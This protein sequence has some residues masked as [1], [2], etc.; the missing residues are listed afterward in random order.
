MLCDG[1]WRGRGHD[2]RV[3][4]KRRRWPRRARHC[5]AAL[6]VS[7]HGARLEANRPS[8]GRARDGPRRRC[9]SVAPAARAGALCRRQVV[10][11]PHD[12]ADAGRRPATRCSRAHIPRIP[13]ASGWQARDRSRRT[14]RRRARSDAVPARHE[15]ELADLRRLEALIDRLGARA[16]LELFDDADHGFHVPARTGRSDADIRAGIVQA[17]EEWID[18]TMRRAIEPAA[19]GA[20]R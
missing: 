9:R 10:R 12:L 20:M 16:T 8:E 14:P 7:L 17:M 2:A 11:R 18:S 15:D 1:A 3:P 5:H 13:A 4:D 6:P 19:M